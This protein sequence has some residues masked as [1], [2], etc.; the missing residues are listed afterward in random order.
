MFPLRL[1]AWHI[2][3]EDGLLDLH[4]WTN[5]E[6]HIS[7]SWSK[8]IAGSARYLDVHGCH[9]S[10]ERHLGCLSDEGGQRA[11]EA[12][13]R[14][15]GEEGGMVR[16]ERLEESGK[17]G[18]QRARVRDSCRE[19]RQTRCR[20]KEV[21]AKERGASKAIQRKTTYDYKK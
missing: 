19:S 21:C 4:D 18:L 9:T 10:L 6:P 11:D 5:G 14:L 2:W 20:T 16:G 1:D 17:K 8:Q 15:E 7:A 13:L 12:R 3:A